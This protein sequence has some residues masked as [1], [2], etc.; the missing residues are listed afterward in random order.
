MRIH[1]RGLAPL[2]ALLALVFAA[3]GD[4]LDDLPLAGGDPGGYSRLDHGSLNARESIAAAHIPCL[5][6]NGDN[7]VSSADGAD[8]SRLPDFNADGVKDELDAAFVDIDLALDPARETGICDN[9]ERPI[10][11]LVSDREGT[12]A[13]ACDRSPQGVLIVAIGGAIPNLEKPD[14]AAGVRWIVNRLLDEF[15]DRDVDTLSIVSGPAFVGTAGEIHGSMETWLVHAVGTLLDQY[16]CLH[17]VLIG[18]SHGAVTSDVVAARL[19]GAYGERILGS[20]SIDRIDDL[21]FGDTQSRPASTA[22]LNIHES[23]DQV[24]HGDPRNAPNVENWD[25]S[26]ELAPVDG[27]EGGERVPVSHSTID[28]GDGVRDRIVD[29]ILRRFD[30]ASPS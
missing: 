11:F 10:D 2:A 15:A 20:V 24:V 27:E 3:C 16:P 8:A 17:A 14:D 25:A 6:L 1:F 13:V 21:Y 9:G 26:A 30:E 23:N 22:V 28:N 4:A 18:H 19:E 7:V 29:W 5:D 12:P